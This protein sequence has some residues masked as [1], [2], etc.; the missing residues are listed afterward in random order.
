M[1]AHRL[2]IRGVECREVTVGGIPISRRCCEEFLSAVTEWA[3]VGR[4][5][6]V[7]FVTAHMIALAQED[8]DVRLA[9]A[10]ADIRNADGTPVAWCASLLSG[11]KV[12]VLDGPSMMPR[13][14]SAAERKHLIVGFVGGQG[15]TLDRL[16]RKVR[17]QHPRLAVGCAISPPFRELRSH[18][19]EELVEAIAQS[20]VQ[21]LFVGLGS[22]KQEKW[23]A[24]HR[25]RVHAVMFGVGAA[26]D[27]YAGEKQMPPKW[28]Q[29]MGLTWMY[30]LAQEPRRLG[31]RN[32][33]YVLRFS[34]IALRQLLRRS[35]SAIQ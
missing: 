27:F 26:F 10:T 28:F 31:R 35:L 24:A 21:I 4:S 7:C 2:D 22:P 25:N 23:M 6:C 14:L 33:Q 9:L 19:D 5:A 11:E 1:N 12:A 20:G 3:R 17:H 32:T 8:E 29:R 13:I 16:V 18:E 34:L 15:S 30:R